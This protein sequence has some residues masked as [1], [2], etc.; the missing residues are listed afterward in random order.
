MFFNDIG[1]HRTSLPPECYAFP[2]A[3]T[4]YTFKKVK[5]TSK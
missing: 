3:I 2:L 1:E 5:Q 4:K